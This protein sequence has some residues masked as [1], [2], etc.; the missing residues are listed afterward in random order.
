MVVDLKIVD[1]EMKGTTKVIALQIQYHFRHHSSYEKTRNSMVTDKW[2]SPLPLTCISGSVN[3]QY[4]IIGIILIT[5]VEGSK[6]EFLE[7]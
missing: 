1:L 6:C 5:I 7:Y 2:P 4:C 3:T